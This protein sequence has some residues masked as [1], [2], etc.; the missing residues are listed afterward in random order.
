MFTC[1][2]RVWASINCTSPATTRCSTARPRQPGRFNLPLKSPELYDLIADPD[3]SYDVAEQ[4]PRV[5][6]DIQARVERLMAG[7]PENIRKAYAETKALTTGSA[8]TGA[9]PRKQ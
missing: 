3:E 1:S 8:A 6:A 7:F 4:H 5:V 2:A 9:L